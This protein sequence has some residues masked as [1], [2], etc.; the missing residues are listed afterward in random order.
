MQNLFL[1]WLDERTGIP[2][3]CDKIRHWSVPAGCCRFLPTMIIFAFLL[4][5]ITGVFLWAYYSPSAQ[6]AW[7]SLFFMQFVLPGG[8]MIRGIHHFAAQLLTVLLGLY[9]LGL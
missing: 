7:E 3:L 9:L 5:A 8:W 4:Q 6:S 2:T 1:Q